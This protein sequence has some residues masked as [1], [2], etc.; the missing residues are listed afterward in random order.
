MEQL[1]RFGGMLAASVLFLL[2]FC[3]KAQAPASADRAFAVRVHGLKNEDRDA[4]Q[5]E[6]NGR[7]D[8][9]LVYACVPAGVLVFEALPAETKQ[10]AQQRALPLLEAKALRARTEELIGGKAEAEAA[11]AQARNR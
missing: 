8:L 9:R 7:I 4:L 5:R 3:L 2:P 1:M 10:Q 6:L 11:C